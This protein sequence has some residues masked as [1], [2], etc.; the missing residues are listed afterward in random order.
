ME[1]GLL[2]DLSPS[3]MPQWVQPMAATLTK[4]RFDDPEWVFE[5]KLDG[6]RYVAFVTAGKATLLT[7]NRIRHRHPAVEAALLAQPLTEFIVDGEMVSGARRPGGPRTRGEQL[8]LYAV[9]DILRFGDYDVTKLPLDVRKQL[10]RD[11]F[12]WRDPLTL[13]EPLAEDGLAAYERACR[14]GWE[15]VMAK[16]RDSVYEHKRSR[17]WLKMKCDATQEFVV[18]GFTDPSGA[19]EGFG[20]LLIGYYAGDDFVYA[21]KLGTG[22]NNRLLRELHAQLLA[23]ELS[24]PPFTAGTGLPKKAAHWVR[25][26]L[27]V[28]VGFMEWTGEGK[29]RH[30]RFIRLRADK[31]PRDVVRETPA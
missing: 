21:G 8:S 14:E 19:R 13:V 22:F 20:A 3:A 6:F 28:D 25:P 26:V 5:R 27:V 16:R 12:T 9:F 2:S 29:L 18:G 1:P 15:G 4:E 23:S 31:S 10:L 7:R 24:S 11:H 30:P 17:H